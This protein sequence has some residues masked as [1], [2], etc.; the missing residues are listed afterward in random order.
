V[1]AL[2]QFS[3]LLL[4]IGMLAVTS[5][6]AK[7]PEPATLVRLAVLDGRVDPARDRTQRAKTGY[8]LADRSRYDDGN[9]GRHFADELA[10]SVDKLWGVQVHPRVDIRAM[11]AQ[12]ERLLADLQPGM[13]PEER[14]DF[15]LSLD[16][17]DYGKELNA[18]YVLVPYMRE[19]RMIQNRAVF[20]WY[21]KVAV[22]YE[23]WD[24]DKGE[25]VAGWSSR[26]TGYFRS[27]RFVMEDLAKR[28]RGKV[29]KSIK[30]EG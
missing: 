8:L 2:L 6:C 19:A 9:A 11:M 7:R 21:S 12:K 10:K 16:P 13:S 4:L 27:Q 30:L 17:V 18:D 22:D 5:G 25:K 28:A 29:R 15:L 3:S 23:L 1:R 26:K 24:V 20:W 14:Y